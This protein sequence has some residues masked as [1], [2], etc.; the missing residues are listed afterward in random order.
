MHSCVLRLPHLHFD[1]HALGVPRR[2]QFD[3]D[4]SLMLQC[5]FQFSYENVLH[6]RLGLVDD[7][8]ELLSAFIV[9]FKF[10][11]EPTELILQI[12]LLEVAC[13]YRIEL[14]F[15]WLCFRLDG[16][17]A[18]YLA[19][20]NLRLNDAVEARHLA[21]LVRLFTVQQLFVDHQVWS[22]G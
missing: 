17:A 7:H 22:Y 18:D 11:A 4:L 21:H 15:E 2:L 19:L 14:K 8:F 5:A 9:H 10:E 20:S 6:Q 13:L 1:G 12:D 3:V 16:Q